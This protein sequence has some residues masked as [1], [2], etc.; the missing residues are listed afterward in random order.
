MKI[1]ACLIT[2]NEEKN[3]ATCLESLKTIVDE[4]IVVDTGSSDQTVAIAKTYGAQI[5]YY[6]W[7]DDFAAAKNYALD[8]AQGEWIIF[9]DADEYFT[10]ET[11]GNVKPYIKKM[12]ENL[13]CHA[14][15]VQIINIDQE[16]GNRE[17]SAFTTIRIFRHKPTIRYKNEIHEEVYNTKGLLNLFMLPNEIKVYHTGYSK[18]I[19]RAKLERN[20]AVILDDVALHGEQIKY[21]RYLCDCYHGL[22]D[23]AQA[24]KYGRLHI[25]QNIKSLGTENIVHTKVIDSLIRNKADAHEI[26]RQIQQAIEKFPNLPDFYGDYARYALEQKEYDVALTY[27]LRAIDIYKNESGKKQVYDSDSFHGKLAYAYFA[28]AEV[29]FLKNKNEEAAAYYMESLLI[30]KENAIAFQRMYTIISNNDPIEIIAMLNGIY[31]R[32]EKDIKFVVEN[33]GVCPKNKVFVYYSNILEKEFSDKP[34]LVWQYQLI[35]LKNYSTFYVKSAESMVVKVRLLAAMLMAQNDPMVFGKQ[36]DMLPECYKRIIQRFYHQNVALKDSDLPYY[37]ELL[38]EILLIETDILDAYLLIVDDFTVDGCL[39]IAKILSN[40]QSYKQ[41]LLLYE[42]ID[43]S[44][45]KD[46]AAYYENIG[47]CYYKLESYAKAKLYFAQIIEQGQGNNR[48]KQLNTW[49]GEKL[50]IPVNG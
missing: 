10:P 36:S 3:I 18:S 11:I 9:L 20:L 47:Y 49:C 25:A 6:K 45:I 24:V 21:Y 44:L 4:I 39:E 28:I 29:Y 38:N 43:S 17:I 15:C 13:Q 34:K 46:Y 30:E 31:T 42:N 12:N 8:K 14:I 37:K 7:H 40:Q 26:K 35:G 1:S 32:T 41:A 22:G 19:I 50:A 16:M 5:Y 33:L 2:K 48:I 23:Y 27:F